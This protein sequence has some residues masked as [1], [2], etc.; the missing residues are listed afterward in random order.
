MPASMTVNSDVSSCCQCVFLVLFLA[1]SITKRVSGQF[2]SG[3]PCA[4]GT[5]GVP[6]LWLCLVTPKLHILTWPP[7]G[8]YCLYLLIYLDRISLCSP[9]YS[10]TYSIDQVALKPGDSPAS[11]SQVMG[12]KMYTPPPRPCSV[13]N[14]KNVV[15]GHV[16]VWPGSW[17]V[18]S[19]LEN[20]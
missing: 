3:V 4:Q 12:L 2:S 16:S 10:E 8:S 14:K 18:S 7:Y 13:L 19:G 6:Q 1:L 11:A 20:L 5:L 15:E 17:A 9:G